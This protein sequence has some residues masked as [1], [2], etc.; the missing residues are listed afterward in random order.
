MP[1]AQT[2]KDAYLDELSDLWSSN[3][4]MQAIVKEMAG[5]AADPKLRQTLEKSVGAIASHTATL[6]SLLDTNGGHGKEHCSGME[7]LVRE[8]R[9]HAL[10]T[11][12]GRPELRDLAIIA[13][14]Q[15]MSHYGLAGFGTAA[16]YA[17]ALNRTEDETKLKE[18][19]SSIYKGDEYST[20]LAEHLERAVA[21]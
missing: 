5:Q 11:Q 9:K 3:D 19:V 8:A 14:Y 2:L 1:A 10:D 16:A 20:H 4:Q 13:Q 7:G 15:R 12:T 21:A 6:K 18:I 17:H